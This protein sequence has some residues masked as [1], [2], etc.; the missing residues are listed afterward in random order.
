MRLW[1]SNDLAFSSRCEEECAFGL[2]WNERLE[3]VKAEQFFFFFFNPGFLSFLQKL[4][5]VVVL[6]LL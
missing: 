4:L 3:E 1:T 5:L 2:N 6:E